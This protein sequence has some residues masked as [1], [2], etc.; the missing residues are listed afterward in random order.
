MKLLQLS[1]SFHFSQNKKKI[2][3]NLLNTFILQ[4]LEWVG[5]C[6]HFSAKLYVTEGLTWWTCVISHIF[7]KC[8]YCIKDRIIFR[9]QKVRKETL[10]LIPQFP[11]SHMQRR[12]PYQ[13]VTCYNSLSNV[14]Q[15]FMEHFS[16]SELQIHYDRQ[17]YTYPQF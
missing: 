8:L 6:S 9:H 1:L 2:E 13:L 11:S 10:F 14:F 17:L 4:T 5:L 12:L 3:K 15:C 7:I 16:T